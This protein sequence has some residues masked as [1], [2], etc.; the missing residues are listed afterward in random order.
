[1]KQIALFLCLTGI[2]PAL[3]YGQDRDQRIADL[4]RQLTETKG[5]VA[6]LQKT[7]E[8]LS[9]EVQALRQPESKSDVATA[10]AT[11]VPPTPPP[12]K[13]ADEKQPD[14]TH[15]F[16]ARIID[17]DIGTN[18]HDHPLEAKP[19]IFIQ[20]R[21]SVALLD[22]SGTAFNPNLRLSRIETRWAGKLNDRLG[23]GMH[24][25]FEESVEGSPETLINKTFLEV[26]LQ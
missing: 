9:K 5:S 18:E 12:S 20:T 14:A 16:A 10:A 22:G 1:M 13:E 24:G 8:S 2:I 26:H 11:P 23:A 3:T 6:A 21:Y 4:E 15:E 17:P 25:Q 7:I 19:E